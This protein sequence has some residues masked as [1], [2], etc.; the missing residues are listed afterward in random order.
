MSEDSSV[1]RSPL[2][3]RETIHLDVRDPDS[4]E[5]VARADCVVDSR[6]RVKRV[7]SVPLH[8]PD[9]AKRAASL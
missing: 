8:E 2:K 1:S 7:V 3:V 5:V 9:A 6:A 4:N